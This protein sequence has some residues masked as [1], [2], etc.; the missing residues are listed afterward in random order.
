MEELPHL[1][2]H[3]QRVDAPAGVVWTAL[4][5]VLRHQVGGSSPIARIVGCDP[6]QGTAEFAGPPGERCL[7][8]GWSRSSPAGSS[9]C[10]GAA[11]SPATR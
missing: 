3:S 9:P 6:A 4:L 5:D 10:A 7:V 1:D 2:E 11:A 8:S